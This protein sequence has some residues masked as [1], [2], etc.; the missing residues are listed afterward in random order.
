[1]TAPAPEVVAAAFGASSAQ[2]LGSGSY[3]DTYLVLDIPGLG[4]KCAAKVLKPDGYDERRATRETEGM[5]RFSGTGVADL[6]EVRTVEIDGKSR[7]AL[8]CEFIDG[9]DVFTRLH[10]NDLPTHKQLRKFARSLLSTVAELHAA[11]TVHRD[12]KPLNIMLRDGKWGAPVLIDFGM[13]RMISDPTITAYG[14]FTGSYAYM[15]PEHLRGEPARKQADL[16]AVGVTLFQ[17]ATGKHPFIPED[18]TAI[19]LDDL[20][21]LVSGATKP[22]PPDLPDDLRTV[23]ERLLEETPHRRGSAARAV[24][25]LTESER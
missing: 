20:V 7:V 18:A 9:G 25:N 16:W 15:P 4:T 17:L 8:V 1:M 3:G 22:L 6:L 24:K 14:T 21:L 13:S 19:S 2:L 5:Q 23:I 11:E 10:E 12:I